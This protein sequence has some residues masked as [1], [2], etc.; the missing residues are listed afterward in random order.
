[1]FVEDENR[2]LLDQQTAGLNPDPPDRGKTDKPCRPLSRH[3]ILH[4]GKHIRQHGVSFQ[5]LQDH[6]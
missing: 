2:C 3:S 4:N 6:V 1:M 5:L